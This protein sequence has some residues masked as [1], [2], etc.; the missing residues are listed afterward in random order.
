MRIKSKLGSN[1]CYLIKARGELA[2]IEVHDS[3]SGWFVENDIEFMNYTG[4]IK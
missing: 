1:S 4:K 2:D 3:I